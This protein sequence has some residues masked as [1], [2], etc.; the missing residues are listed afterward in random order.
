M[1]VFRKVQAEEQALAAEL[2]ARARHAL[3][4]TIAL[5]CPLPD[6]ARGGVRLDLSCAVVDPSR[7]VDGV[8]FRYRR[9]GEHDFSSL[10]LR[11]ETPSAWNGALPGEWTE[12]EHGFDLELYPVALDRNGGELSQP[13]TSTPGLV[14]VAPGTVADTRPFYRSPWFWAAGAT[15]VVAA[16]VG[17]WLLY[18]HA[19]KLPEHDVGPFVMP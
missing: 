15:V 17:G 16:V 1:A 19:T 12:N 6:T 9:R 7:A 2:A 4:D 14:K 3:I 8:V 18:E 5:D 10:A 11:H 13:G